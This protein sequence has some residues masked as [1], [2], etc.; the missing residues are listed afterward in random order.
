M[1]QALT[2]TSNLSLSFSSNNFNP[3]FHKLDRL[4]LGAKHQ[5]PHLEPRGYICIPIPALWFWW[6]QPLLLKATL[7]GGWVGCSKRSG[8]DLAQVMTTGR[9]TNHVY[10]RHISALNVHH[11]SAWIRHTVEKRPTTGHD[12]LNRPTSKDILIPSLRLVYISAFDTMLCL[13]QSVLYLSIGVVFCC[14]GQTNNKTHKQ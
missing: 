7:E 2:Q 3:Y 4:I 10:V 13:Q 8:F 11:N 9:P 1:F 6:C 12:R 5:T 14:I